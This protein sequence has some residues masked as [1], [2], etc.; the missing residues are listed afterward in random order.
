MSTINLRKFGV[1]PEKLT[2]TYIEYQKEDLSPGQRI[3]NRFSFAG[4]SASNLIKSVGDVVAAGLFSIPVMF[5]SSK[6]RRDS[7]LEKAKERFQYGDAFA[8]ASFSPM[9]G[10]ERIVKRAIGSNKS[11][12]IP[13]TVAI[14]AANRRN[15]LIDMG[16]TID[17]PFE[18]TCSE[19]N[20]QQYNH[21][22]QDLENTL[23][24]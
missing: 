21:D 11:N 23:S 3:Y 20:E 24:E 14:E 19:I 10:I 16:N 22:I 12:N 18:K 17:E 13:M 15:A 4:K 2:K 6:E 9:Q 8:M 1:N 5:G 7:F